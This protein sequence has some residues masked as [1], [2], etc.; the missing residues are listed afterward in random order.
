MVE[1]VFWVALPMTLYGLMAATVPTPGG[2][3]RGVFGR[4]R[5]AARR[6]A[7]DETITAR[8]AAPAPDDPLAV[9]AVQMRLGVL[10]DH[11]RELESDEHIWAR[12]RK[13]EAAQAAYDGL[14][15][16]ACRLAGIQ[17]HLPAEVGSGLRRCTEPE[18]FED[19]LAL[20]GRGWSW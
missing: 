11:I 14:L 9:L 10:A 8:P 7:P 2:R 16:E 13:L 3:R 6:Q 15:D 17:S 12:A 5:T 18:R 1:T 4:L 19:E 20:A